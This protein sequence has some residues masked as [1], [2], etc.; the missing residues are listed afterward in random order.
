MCK[1]ASHWRFPSYEFFQ[2]AETPS[3]CWPVSTKRR[4]KGWAIM[5]SEEE[6]MCRWETSGWKK[7]LRADLV[8][9]ALPPRRSG[10]K[11]DPGTWRGVIT[12]QLAHRARAYAALHPAAQLAHRE[13]ASRLLLTLNHSS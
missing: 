2:R 9:K 12:V 8:P 5:K 11:G 4:R 13:R 10:I 7:H 1:Q 3:C 6:E